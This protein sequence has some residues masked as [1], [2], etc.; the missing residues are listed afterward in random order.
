MRLGTLLLFSA[1]LRLGVL[2]LKLELERGEE[3]LKG[4]NLAAALNCPLLPN[5]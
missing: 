5:Q 2:A 4:Q 3:K 1:P